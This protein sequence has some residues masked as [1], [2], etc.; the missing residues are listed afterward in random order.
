MPLQDISNALGPVCWLWQRYSYWAGLQMLHTPYPHRPSAERCWS[1]GTL[2]L[3]ERHPYGPVPALV[4][5]DHP[6]YPA[7]TAAEHPPPPPPPSDIYVSIELSVPP[8]M[9]VTVHGAVHVVEKESVHVTEVLAGATPATVTRTLPSIAQTAVQHV[10]ETETRLETK[11]RE[12]VPAEVQLS[13]LVRTQAIGRPLT[14]TVTT[15][16]METATTTE[17]VNSVVTTT[18]TASQLLAGLPKVVHITST[19]TVCRACHVAQT[20]SAAAPEY[21]RPQRPCPI[22]QQPHQPRHAP[23]TS[24]LW[25]ARQGWSTRRP[26][27]RSPSATPYTSLSTARTIQSPRAHS[28]SPASGTPSPAPTPASSPTGTTGWPCSR[29]GTTWSTPPTPPGGTVPT[30]RTVEPVWCLPSTRPGTRPSR[31]SRR[32]RSPR[33]API[34]PPQP[35]PLPP[36]PP[37]PPFPPPLC[38]KEE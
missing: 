1:T 24:S 37:C 18:A 15:I 12:T 4:E 30:T 3:T 13:H 36:P 17:T 35:P 31:P 32:R 21:P 22:R 34:Q 25:A 8:E 23:R 2:L 11:L 5:L 38:W 10:T 27:S 20:P 9:V 29:P 7:S 6:E 14:E 26:G 16:E 19:V 33:T 28:T